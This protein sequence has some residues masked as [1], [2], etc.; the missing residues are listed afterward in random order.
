M[1]DRQTP[2]DQPNSPHL[3]HYKLNHS[4]SSVQ[5]NTCTVMASSAKSLRIASLLPSLT[6]ICI[7]L[8]LADRI[9]AVTHECNVSLLL[10]HRSQQNKQGFYVITKSGLSHNL[11][12]GQIDHVVKAASRG[13]GGTCEI[14]SNSAVTMESLSLYPIL[15]SE[16]KKA[17]PSMVLT[18]T[19]C[20]VCA[21][22][23]D[24]VRSTIAACQLD[25]QDDSSTS[26]ASDIQIHSFAPES[27]MDVVETFVTVSEICNVPERGRKLKRTFMDNLHQLKSLCEKYVQNRKK[28]K[29]LLLEWMDPPYD[30]GHWIPDMIEWVGCEVCKVGNKR[31]SV[32][33]KEITWDGIYKVD[34][35]IVLVA[36]CGFDLKRNIA[37]AK[38]S[39]ELL[40][41]LRAAR[42]QK[43]FACNGDLNFARPGPE[44]LGGVAVVAATVYGSDPKFRY[45]MNQLDFVREG[46]SMEWEHVNVSLE[47]KD[48]ELVP[49]MQL[50]LQAGI[51]IVDI[52]DIHSKS[53]DFS[54][55][56]KQACDAG[57]LSYEDP[58]TG[59]HVFTELAHKKRGK[60][61]GNGCRHCPYYHVNVKNKAK[62][63]MQPA[64]LYEGSREPSSF[65][66]SLDHTKGKDVKV[67]F[68]SGGKDSF[69]SIR[70]TLKKYIL[71]KKIE[72]LCIILLT[73][74]D[75]K[76]RIV[77]HQEIPIKTI[78][79]QARHLNIPLIGVPLHPGSSESYVDRLRAALDVVVKRVGRGIDA[80][81]FG[82]LHLEHIRSWRDT[83]LKELGIPLEYPLWQLPY[84][85]LSNDL[86]R[87][88]I[89]IRVSAS[90][91]DYIYCN[92]IY[93]RCLMDRAKAHNADTFGENGEF[94]TCVE[95]WTASRDRVLGLMNA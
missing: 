42:E 32:K 72:K 86:E 19:L 85:D 73:T 74:F 67:L 61:C 51:D 41:P 7:A 53:D 12:Q 11:T 89:K 92:E 66:M 56:H 31:G 47:K 30:G 23:P 8:G 36:N 5:I 6:D 45:E 49:A 9:V 21:P 22:S 13:Q 58:A 44:L 87:S 93:D 52:E 26:R 63:I 40:Q 94:H 65:P 81:I 16:F 60:C 20:Q 90:T 43:I 78:E 10:Q 62:K 71:E 2:T 50:N 29:V 15:E 95:I 77:G 37:D 38:S 1:A 69:L 75:S 91:V 17:N 14:G 59:Y 55:L 33:S 18:Q 64:F 34:P 46:F 28:P 4:V 27:L 84:D 83:A 68:F 76:S 79:K 35:D 88:G 54:T 39:S 57:E 48:K 25:N 80:L 24:S 70:A 82:D 3:S